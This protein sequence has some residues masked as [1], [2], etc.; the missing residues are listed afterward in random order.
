MANCWKT[1]VFIALAI[2]TGTKGQLR[3]IRGFDY[4]S[5]QL[6]E[7]FRPVSGYLWVL[8]YLMP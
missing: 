2:F 7:R 6:N 8:D 3:I 5:P 1:G 4:Q